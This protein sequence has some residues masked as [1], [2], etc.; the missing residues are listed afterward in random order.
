LRL[1]EVRT[2]LWKELLDIARDRRALALMII[3]PLV[4]LPLLALLA[5]GLSSAQVTSVYIQVN[6]TKSMGIAEWLGE[7]LVNQSEQQG[8]RVNVTISSRPPPQV[9]DIE[10]MFPQG[11]YSNLTSLDGVAT[12]IVRVMVGSYAAQEV[13][14][15]ITG[16][17][18]GLSSQV[19][20]SRVESLAR[21]AN[22]TISPQ[23]CL[24]PYP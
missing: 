20:N 24:I 10:V 6:D 19:V 14:S 23:R 22:V 3:V 16:I 17:V 15:L 12:L 4:G 9:Y 11:F 8:L 5:G 18:S 1:D 2:I 21:L 7:S 13:D